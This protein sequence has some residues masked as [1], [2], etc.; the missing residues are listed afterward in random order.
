MID[1]VPAAARRAGVAA[2]VG[3][4]LLAPGTDLTS[5]EQSGCTRLGDLLAV[6]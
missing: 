1:A 4:T 6:Q 3:V 2:A 5:L